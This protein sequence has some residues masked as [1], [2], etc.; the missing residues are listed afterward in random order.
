MSKHEDAVSVMRVH[1]HLCYIEVV[2][3]MLRLAFAHCVLINRH[4]HTKL[5][6]SGSQMML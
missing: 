2:H 5:A 4:M 6:L 1:L 3:A